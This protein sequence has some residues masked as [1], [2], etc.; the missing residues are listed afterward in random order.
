[1]IY[2]AILAGGIGKRMERYSVPKQFI[3]LAGKPVIIRTLE[4]FVANDRFDRIYIAVHKDWTAHM[5]ELLHAFFSNEQRTRIS[6][7]EGG[8]ERLD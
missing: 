1:M 2:A 3:L 6:I 5:E 4:K 7:V 8:K